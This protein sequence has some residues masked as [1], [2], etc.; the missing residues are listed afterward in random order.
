MHMH[1]SS[2]HL[3]SQSYASSL[4]RCSGK[5]LEHFLNTVEEQENVMLHLWRGMLGAQE[6]LSGGLVLLQQMWTWLVETR[7]T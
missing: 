3:H 7:H 5:S 6:R 1:V 4:A 2:V